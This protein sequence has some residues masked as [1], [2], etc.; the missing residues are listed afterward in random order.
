MNS[1]RLHLIAQEI[2]RDLKNTTMEEKLQE[3]VTHLQNQVNQP[4]EPQH[5]QS[6]SQTLTQLYQVLESSAINDFRQTWKQTVEEIGGAGLFGREL[7]STIEEIFSR[8]QIT[9]SVALEEIQ[10]IHS[11]IHN[12][13]EALNQVIAGFTQLTVG[14]DD[15][16]PGQSELGVLVPRNFVE[17]RLDN[18]GKELSELNAI[19]NPFVELSTGSRPGFEIRSI[20]SSDLTVFL[21]LAPE[22]A[23]CIAVAVERIIT[24]Y[25]GLLEIRKLHGDLEDQ[26]VPKQKLKGVEDHAN[27]LMRA[28][29]KKMLPELIKDFYQ[30]SDKGRKNELETELRHA[31]TKIANRVDRGYNIEI[32]VKPVP[33]EDKETEGDEAEDTL[34]VRIEQIESASKTLQFLRQ[35]GKPILCLPESDDS[36]SKDK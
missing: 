2:V 3:L 30:K 35:D 9:P 22:A 25:K 12:L 27:N 31:L 15:L 29:I 14:L 33:K 18:F 10:K 34:Q 6:V 36:K 23:A 28:G 19:F 24:L 7:R 4:N 20:S 5:Q 26:G 11:S 21:D 17:N 32:R 1:E 16:E 13:H 8:N